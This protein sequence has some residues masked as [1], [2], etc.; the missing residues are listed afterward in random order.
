MRHASGR[1]C[2]VDDER[3]RAA[4]MLFTTAVG[5]P[6]SLQSRTESS[7]LNSLPPKL[8]GP[9]IHPNDIY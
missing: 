2:H 3:F 5:I 4:D 7:D 1:E 8:A 9:G 6:S